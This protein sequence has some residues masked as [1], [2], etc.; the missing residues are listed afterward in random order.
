MS[1]TAAQKEDSLNPKCQWCH[2]WEPLGCAF[3][4]CIY[5]FSECV[6]GGWG[7]NINRVDFFLVRPCGMQDLSSLIRDRTLH[8]ECGV[9]TT[10]PPGK[11]HTDGIFISR[12]ILYVLFQSLKCLRDVISIHRDLSYYFLTAREFWDMA[13]QSASHLPAG[14]PEAWGITIWRTIMMFPQQTRC[15]LPRSCPALDLSLL[16]RLPS[17]T[18][19]LSCLCCRQRFSTEQFHLLSVFQKFLII[20]RTILATLF[21]NKILVC[22]FFF[23]WICLFNCFSSLGIWNGKIEVWLTPPASIR[24]QDL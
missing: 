12:V 16:E 24:S 21:Y 10:G 4:W 14:G 8:W 19:I 18:A 3:T 1:T 22:Y 23:F 13:L 20:S 11:S 7:L 5:Y 15:P 9:L 2:C 17:F 6:W